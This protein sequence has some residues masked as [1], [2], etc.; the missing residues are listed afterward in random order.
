MNS[1]N[2]VRDGLITT[3]LRNVMGQFNFARGTLMSFV[4]TLRPR[5]LRERGIW[6]L[7]QHS[8]IGKPWGGRLGG[9]A[10]FSNVSA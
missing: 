3:A 6:R 8:C 4:G 7:N 9:L 10:K 1:G 2:I 5:M